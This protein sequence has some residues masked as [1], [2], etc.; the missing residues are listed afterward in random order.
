MPR[1]F[2]PG[3][4][5]LLLGSFILFLAWSAFQ[6]ST[7]GT[8]VTDRDYYNQGLKYNSTMV[9][10]RAAAAMGWQI[11]PKLSEGKLL[12]RLSDRD[13]LPVSAANGFLHLYS[14]PGSDLQKL[15]LSEIDAGLYRAELP[16]SIKGETTLRIEFE[17]DGARLN[18]QL[19]LKI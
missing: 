1:H 6:A 13:G 11:S 17:R 16:V 4:I 10:K 3:L 5:I 12:L 18:R 9:E 19:L 15:P 14:R 8:Q 2:Y 7:E